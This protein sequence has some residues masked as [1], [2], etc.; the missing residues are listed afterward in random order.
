VIAVVIEVG[1]ADSVKSNIVLEP[2][3]LI[4]TKYVAPLSV[5]MQQKFVQKH[6]ILA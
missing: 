1:V 4:V 5:T 6:T 3:K 2:S